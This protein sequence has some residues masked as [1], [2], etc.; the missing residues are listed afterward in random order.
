MHGPQLQLQCYSRKGDPADPNHY[1]PICLQSIACKLFASLFEQ[2]LLDAGVQARLWKSQLGFREGHCTEDAIFVAL[3]RVEQA[4]AQRNGQIRLVALD[5]KQACDS[6]DL[7]S[8]CDALRRF[9]IP[10]FVG[11]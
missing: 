1:R 5:W 3:R 8:L 10:D 6:I 11:K 7:D 4:C 2:P 9:G